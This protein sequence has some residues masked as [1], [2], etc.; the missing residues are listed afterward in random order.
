MSGEWSGGAQNRTW[1]RTGHRGGPVTG[2]TQRGQRLFAELAQTPF[3]CETCGGTHA[4]AEHSDCRN[5]EARTMRP[6]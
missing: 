6:P 2:D 3:W 5:R 4:L 1:R